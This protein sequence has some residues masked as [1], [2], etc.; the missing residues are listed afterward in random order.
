MDAENK[1]WIRPVSSHR[2]IGSTFSLVD[3]SPFITSCTSTELPTEQH[4]E[5]L[6]HT[7]LPTSE[8]K[9]SLIF[10][11]YA[12]KFAKV[13]ATSSHSSKPDRAQVN[14]PVTP[15][16]TEATISCLVVAGIA[17]IQTD[18]YGMKRNASVPTTGQTGPAFDKRHL[19][20]NLRAPTKQS[21]L[22]TNQAPVFRA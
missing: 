14:S 16:S 2:L 13:E 6:C 19:P 21:G 11:M 3:N 12:W 9:L 20:S 4:P 8:C 10:Y 15:P 18:Y 5:R 22:E 1:L 7:L 17:G